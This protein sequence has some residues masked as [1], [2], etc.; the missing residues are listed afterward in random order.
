VWSG[1]GPT[2][3]ILSFAC[4][5]ESIQRKG[6]PAAAVLRTSLRC[7]PSWAAIK[8]RPSTAGVAYRA[9]ELK[10][11]IADYPQL[12]C[13]AQRDRRGREQPWQQL[14]QT[15]SLPFHYG[16]NGIQ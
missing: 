16:E 1:L 4:P 3:E 2:A 10:Q 14:S 6:H 13:A 5:N 9:A 11:L 12:D 7:S 8:T 15:Q